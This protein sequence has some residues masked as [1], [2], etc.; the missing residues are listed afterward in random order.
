MAPIAVAVRVVVAAAATKAEGARE[1]RKT[2]RSTGGGIDTAGGR[3][4]TGFMLVFVMRI[5]QMH[6]I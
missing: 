3:R 2:Y 6:F 4:A 5:Q 1:G